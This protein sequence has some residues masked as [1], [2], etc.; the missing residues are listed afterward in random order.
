M[1]CWKAAQN[2]EACLTFRIL[3]AGWW[4]CTL[5]RLPP[6][7]DDAACTGHVEACIALHSPACCIVLTCGAADHM[8][9]RA[10]RAEDDLTHSLGNIIKNNKRMRSLM[11]TGSPEHILREAGDMLQYFITTYFDNTKPG[12]PVAQQRSG[13]CAASSF[14][15]SFRFVCTVCLLHNMPTLQH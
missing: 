7:L 10:C 14:L 11:E 15:L 12:V 5:S 13:R 3:F 8:R 1:L 4:T 6:A 9:M 2:N